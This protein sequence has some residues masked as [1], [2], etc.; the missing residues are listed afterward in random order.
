MTN[1]TKPQNGGWTWWK[2]GGVG[3]CVGLLGLCFAA[4]AENAQPEPT[5]TESCSGA[6]IILDAGA[7]YAAYLW[8]TGERTQIINIGNDTET[9]YSVTVF[10]AYGNEGSD[11]H[12]AEGGCADPAPPPPTPETP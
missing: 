12:Q 8:N 9:V 10:D 11:S 3:L 1:L 2:I 7:G 5:I 6:D 4:P